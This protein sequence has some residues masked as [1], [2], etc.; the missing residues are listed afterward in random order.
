MKHPC[1]DYSSFQGCKINPIQIPP[2]CK[3][4][5][6]LVVVKTCF[7]WSAQCGCYLIG[8]SKRWVESTYLWIC[9][10][11]DARSV[12]KIYRCL[13]GFTNAQKAVHK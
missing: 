12:S 4:L 10:H 8:L 6:G 2:E 1:M 7:D 5:P 13:R 3:A 11:I 9:L